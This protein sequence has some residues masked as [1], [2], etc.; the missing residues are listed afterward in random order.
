LPIAKKKAVGIIPF[1][2]CDIF[3]SDKFY[4]AAEVGISGV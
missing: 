3:I 2:D 1:E 4:P